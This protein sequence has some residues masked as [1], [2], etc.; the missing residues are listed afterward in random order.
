M[1]PAPRRGRS[2]ARLRLGG[3]RVM[4]AGDVGELER[5]LGELKQQLP[6]GSTLAAIIAD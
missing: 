5:E 3:R 2:L 1:D 6:D 4:A